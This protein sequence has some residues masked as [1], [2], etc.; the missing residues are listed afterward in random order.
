MQEKEP[1]EVEHP[2][3]LCGA[4]GKAGEVV[5]EEVR[6]DGDGSFLEAV[7]A[8]DGI[9]VEWAEGGEG[10]EEGDE[11]EEE[12]DPNAT[13]VPTRRGAKSQCVYSQSHYL[14]PETHSRVLH[15]RPPRRR[16]QVDDDD[17]DVPRPLWAPS[18]PSRQYDETTERLNDDDAMDDLV[19]SKGEPSAAVAAATASATS[20]TFSQA[21]Q[22]VQE[23]DV[24]M[25]ANLLM[26]QTCACSTRD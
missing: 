10:E 20:M 11:E 7:L 1:L 6:G 21:L 18:Y 23:P 14:V 17:D 19:S 4:V 25:L 9:C 22:T 5:R 3:L 13:P 24:R 26:Q 12:G 8:G 16:P 2:H 15:T